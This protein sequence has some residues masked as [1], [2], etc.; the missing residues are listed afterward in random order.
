MKK[1]KNINFI[2]KSLDKKKLFFCLLL[3]AFLD[4]IYYM[5]PFAFTLFLTLPFTIEKAIIVVGVFVISKTLRVVGNYMLSKYTGNYLYEY[6]KIQY[7]EY[8]KKLSKLPIE[9]ISK[10]QTGY[11][12]QIIEKIV[13]L[14]Q[15]ILTS[16]YFS[17]VISFFFLFYTLYRQSIFLF[18]ASLLTSILC[19]T[20]SILILKK[21]NH[22]VEKLYDCDYE[23]FSMYNDYISNIRTV[24]LLNHD[25]YFVGKIDKK[26]KNCLNEN[27]KYVDYY[28]IE[29]ALRNM[30]ILMP[31]L[32]GLLKAIIDLSHGID[33][34]GIITFYISLQVEMGFIFEELSG[35]IISWFELKAIKKKIKTIFG[36]LDNRQKLKTFS[37]IELKDIVINYPKSNLEIKIDNLEINRGDK[38][39][40]MGKSGQGK[41]SLV[42]L[43]LGSLT[44]YSGTILIDDNDPS[45]SKLDIGVVSQ[46]IE[47]FNMSI[48]DNICLDKKVADEMLIRYLKEL[49]LNELLSFEDGLNTIVGE[50]GFKLSTGQ[51]RRLN[52]LRSYLMD[53]EIYIL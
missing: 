13:A 33:T 18:I 16:E 23:Y 14:V 20:L 6:S 25:S 12:E 35:V 48:K 10:Y 44:Y 7:R 46:E 43:I 31:F 9:V 34:I 47:L 28:S 22:Q 3:E 11:F 1:N 51:K 50:K 41:T 53:K 27:R 38:I 30:L 36:T 26:S 2:F 8:Y 21:A 24:K 49:E 19:I 42:N 4:V 37:K 15:K 39:S 5:V 52:I 40:I 17:I 32:L 45:Q 29:E